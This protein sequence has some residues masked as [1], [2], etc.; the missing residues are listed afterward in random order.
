MYLAS[1]D[2]PYSNMMFVMNASTLIEQRL[3]EVLA[4]RDRL[5][6]EN[7]QLRGRLGIHLEQYQGWFSKNL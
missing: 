2:G 4:D 3:T 1:R 6:E 7:Q 5:R